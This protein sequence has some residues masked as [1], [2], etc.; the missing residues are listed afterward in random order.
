[1][2]RLIL[3]RHAKSS[4]KGDLDDFDRPLNGRGRRDAPRVGAWLRARGY[5]PDAAL[6]SSAVRARSTFARLYADAAPPPARFLDALYHAPAETMLR[7][8]RA[9]RG[10]VVMLVGHNPGIGAFASELLAAPAEDPD[11]RRYP[12]A[13]TAVIDCAVADWSD[14]DRR[15]GR[16]VDFVIPKRFG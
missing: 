9:A 13:A 5:Q 12:T 4:W 14:L 6:V 8:L 2:K 7:A 16:L 10:D 3:V 15:A 1:M 11:F